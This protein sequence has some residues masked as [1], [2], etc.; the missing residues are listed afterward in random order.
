[1]DD[2]IKALTI[3]RKYAN[4]RWPTHC[5]HDTLYI[6]GV[7]PGDVSNEDKMELDRL[8]FIVDEVDEC[9]LS[10]KFGSA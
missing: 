2:L 10:F 7:N 6:I 3:F 1:M 8:G 5:E 4:E 9:F